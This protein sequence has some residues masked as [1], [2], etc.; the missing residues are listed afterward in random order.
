MTKPDRHPYTFTVLRYAHDCVRQEFVNVGVVLF[1]GHSKK[2]FWKGD[3]ELL[4]AQKLWGTEA[5][6]HARKQ[7]KLFAKTFHRLAKESLYADSAY[8]AA[9]RV[10]PHDGLPWSWSP[11]GSGVDTSPKKALASIYKRMVS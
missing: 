11:M 3:L 6:E 9:I 10:V 2:L 5:T 8:S 1:C 7:M 4:R